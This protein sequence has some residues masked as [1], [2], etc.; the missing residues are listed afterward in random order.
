MSEQVQDFVR[1][2]DRSPVVEGYVLLT[3]GAVYTLANGH[4]FKLTTEECRALPAGYPKWKPHY[5]D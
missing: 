5:A 3:R 1:A 4:I 2:N